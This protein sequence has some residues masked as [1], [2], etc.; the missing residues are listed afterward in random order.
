MKTSIEVPMHV[1]RSSRAF[2]TQLISCHFY[3]IHRC[4]T[5]SNALDD[6]DEK[7]ATLEIS[8]TIKVSEALA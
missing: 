6:D 8:T 3:R 2:P 5:A 1:M 7:H 4:Y